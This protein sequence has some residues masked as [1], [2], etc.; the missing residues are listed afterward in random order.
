MAHSLPCRADTRR[1]PQ[2]A[3]ARRLDER[4]HYR[5]HMEGASARFRIRVTMYLLDTN[6]VSMLD[7]RRQAHAPALIEWLDRNG[8]SLFLSVMTIVEIDAGVLKLRRERKS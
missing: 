3:C 4:A 6:V 5:S 1:S 8:A 2:P 7:P